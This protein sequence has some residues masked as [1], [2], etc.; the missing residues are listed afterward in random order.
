MS[1]PKN[2]LCRRKNHLRIVKLCSVVGCRSSERKKPTGL[3]T[4]DRQA[5]DTFSQVL[6]TSSPSST[7]KSNSKPHEIGRGGG[8]G[9]TPSVFS[10]CSPR[11]D[12]PAI[13]KSRQTSSKNDTLPQNMTTRTNT[14]IHNTQTTHITR[15][16]H[17][18]QHA[19]HTI[20]ST[21]NTQHT[22][23]TT[24]STYNTQHTTTR[25]THYTQHAQRQT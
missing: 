5:S 21:R 11:V 2:K 14:P 24:R 18:T 6:Q 17:H 4:H 19:G 7:R 25:S 16:T 8:R 23:H 22:A 12:G 13:L 3:I 1:V 10:V 15:N 20:H 9:K